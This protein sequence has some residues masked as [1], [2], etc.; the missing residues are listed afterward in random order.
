M[1]HYFAK[2]RPTKELHAWAANFS[3]DNAVPW[4]YYTGRESDQLSGHDA[5]YLMLDTSIELYLAWFYG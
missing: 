5:R 4:L 1:M 3:I 2:R